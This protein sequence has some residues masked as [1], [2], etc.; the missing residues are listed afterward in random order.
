MPHFVGDTLAH[1]R[2]GTDLVLNVGGDNCVSSAIN[3]SLTAPVLRAAG[4]KGKILTLSSH[5]GEVD[6]KALRR[7]LLE[8]LGPAD[9]YRAA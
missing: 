5:N 2:N 9:Y 6:V 3:E 1:L 4:G 7:A 8:T